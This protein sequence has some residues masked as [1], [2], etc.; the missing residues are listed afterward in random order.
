MGL[1]PFWRGI[2][3]FIL[4][5]ALTKPASAQTGGGKIVSN[6]TIGGAIAGAVAGVVVLVIVVYEV[7]KKKAVTG[8]VTTGE[9]GLTLTDEADSQS[10]SLTGHTADVKTGDRMKLRGHKVSKK[11]GGTKTTS[12]EVQKVDRDFGACRP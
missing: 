2:L 3:A 11:D 8:C 12:W 10:Y 1:K 9:H 5:V 4:C 7:S 6:S